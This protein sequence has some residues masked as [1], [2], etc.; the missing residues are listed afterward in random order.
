MILEELFFETKQFGIQQEC[1][2]LG[3]GVV[4]SDNGFI[5]FSS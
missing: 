3:G 2:Y 1:D 5:L 4:K